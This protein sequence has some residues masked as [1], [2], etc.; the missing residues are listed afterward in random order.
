MICFLYIY[1]YIYIYILN[2][3]LKKATTSL[4]RGIKKPFSEVALQTRESLKRPYFPPL[5]ILAGTNPIMLLLLFFFNPIWFPRKSI[6]RLIILVWFPRKSM[7]NPQGKPKKLIFFSP[8]VFWICSRGLF[9][10]MP[11]DL[12]FTNPK[13]TIFG[14]GWRTQP[15]PANHDQI[16][17]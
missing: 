3:K 6:P 13:S 4:T 9:A 8:C 15:L 2:L 17:K 10:F 16:T 5:S 1:I 11:L 14:L 12:N 7:Q